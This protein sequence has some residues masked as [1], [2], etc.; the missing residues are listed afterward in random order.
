MSS[1]L[2]AVDDFLSSHISDERIHG[3]S[4]ESSDG[5]GVPNNGVSWSEPGYDGT[6]DYRIRQLSYS[7]LLTLHACP[8]KFQ[9]YKLRTTE[10]LPETV[11]SSVTFSFGHVIGEAIQLTFQGFSEQEII[12][13]AFVQWLKAPD[14]FAEDQK[15][16]KSLW[17]ALLAIK[18]F[19][20]ARESGF[21]NDYELVYFDGKPACELSFCI[22]FPDGFRYRGHVDVVLRH[23]TTGE[24]LVLEV[25]TTGAASTNPTTYKNS[26]QAIGYSIVLDAIYPGLSGYSV[27]YLVYNTKLGEYQTFPFAKTFLQ[28]ALWI[29]ELLL[30]IETIKM[31]EEAQIY[32]MHGESCFS[33]FRECEYINSCTLS[34]QYLTKPC[35]PHEEDKVDYQIDISLATLIETQLSKEVKL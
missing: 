2:P 22:N 30:D 13:R 23:K 33:F 11:K 8:R 4:E 7:S 35:A 24:V 28:R 34:T 3:D 20:S 21:L 5:F 18:R 17:S 12:W 27:L 6:I 32:P 26:A 15:L 14:L 25:K 1:Q 31:Y 29:R 19:I 9:L 16:D 10:K